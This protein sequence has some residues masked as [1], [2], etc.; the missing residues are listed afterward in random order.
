VHHTTSTTSLLCKQQV[1][2]LALSEGDLQSGSPPHPDMP[3]PHDSMKKATLDRM[4]KFVHADGRA[5]F[6]SM[7]IISNRKCM[8]NEKFTSQVTMPPPAVTTTLQQ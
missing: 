5:P 6:G 7:G 8:A 4:H 2:L 3:L 1:Y